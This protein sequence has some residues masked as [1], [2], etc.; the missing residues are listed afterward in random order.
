[1]EGPSSG[2]VE[3]TE[4]AEAFLTAVPDA[5]SSHDYAL[6]A[7]LCSKALELKLRIF[8]SLALFIPGDSI[9]RPNLIFASLR[10]TSDSAAIGAVYCPS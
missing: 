10:T 6:A 5:I 1:M 2:A 3:A 8:P 4:H 9:P 7:E